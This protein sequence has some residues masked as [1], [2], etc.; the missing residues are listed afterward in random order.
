MEKLPKENKSE[1]K[2]LTLN[3]FDSKSMN[4]VLNAVSQEMDKG[5]AQIAEETAEYFSPG[6]GV[7]YLCLIESKGTFVN[8]E[9]GVV[10]EQ[11]AIYFFAKEKDS[12]DDPKRYIDAS[13]IIVKAF[14]NIMEKYGA[15]G[16]A[17]SVV[18]LGQVANGKRK[19]NDYKIASI[20]Q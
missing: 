9:D 19:Y 20:H 2:E 18:F 13:T 10:K 11:K 14:E 7:E 16:C 8:E 12:K 15:F 1:S 4:S 17:V 6:E 3:R 5:N